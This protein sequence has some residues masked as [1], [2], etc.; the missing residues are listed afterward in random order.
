[1]NEFK[2]K[3]MQKKKERNKNKKVKLCKLTGFGISDDEDVIWTESKL[4][5]VFQAFRRV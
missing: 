3:L 2:C 4:L 1:M 5:T